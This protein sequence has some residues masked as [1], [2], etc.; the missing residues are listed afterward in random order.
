[1]KGMLL[2]AAVAAS[3]FTLASP[4]GPWDYAGL[5][6]DLERVAKAIGGSVPRGRIDARKTEAFLARHHEDLAGIRCENGSRGWHYVCTFRGPDGRGHIGVVVD[7]TQPTHT[8]AFTPLRRALPPGPEAS[9]SKRAAWWAAEAD[10]ACTATRA[11]MRPDAAERMRRGRVTR[12]LMLAALVESLPVK[13]QL[14]ARLS[15]LPRAA[16]DD[17]ASGSLLAALDED[18][19]A[20]ERV[21]ATLQARG[22]AARLRDWLRGG[23]RRSAK[24]GQLARRLGAEECAGLFEPERG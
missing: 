17:G 22:S 13:R 21:L 7:G 20:H 16:G 12:R 1:M 19:R 10:R 4:L 9:E 6:G 14:A 11:R 3:L 2:V 24:L 8:S 23:Y 15:G 5:R 18:V